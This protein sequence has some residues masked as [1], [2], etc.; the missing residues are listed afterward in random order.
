MFRKAEHTIELGSVM[1]GSGWP[2]TIKE[3]VLEKYSLGECVNECMNRLLL[4]RIRL[5]F[6][7]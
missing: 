3:E 6:P 4:R 7:E 5:D 2:G 1:F